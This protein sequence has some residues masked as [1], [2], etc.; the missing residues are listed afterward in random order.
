MIDKLGSVAADVVGLN[1][2]LILVIGHPKS[3]KT[4][5]L[6]Q[7]S[8]DNNA[9]LLN[10]GMELGAKLINFTT[11]RRRHYAGTIL[12]ELVEDRKSDI[13]L[14][15]NIEILFDQTLCV[16]PLTLLKQLSYARCVIA[17]WPGVFRDDELIYA[18]IGHPEYKSFVVDGFVP[19]VIK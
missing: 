11:V 19:F 6:R 14:L 16:N 8:Q 2:K 1:S 10:L 7:F 17:A 9:P 12:R 13:V 15:D 18:Q 3:G 4:V 5:L